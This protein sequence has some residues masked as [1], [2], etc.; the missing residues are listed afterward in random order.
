VKGED[1]L[2]HGQH[3]LQVPQRQ[4]VQD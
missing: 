4:E 1:L 2:L 3:H